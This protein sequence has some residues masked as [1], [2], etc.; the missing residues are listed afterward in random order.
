MDKPSKIKSLKDAVRLWCL[1]KGYNEI[2]GADL[3]FQGENKTVG[4][5]LKE[6]KTDQEL[7]SEIMN[8]KSICNEI[9]VVITDQAERAKAVS[10]IPK[11]CGLLCYAN[12]FGLGYMY[13]VFKEATPL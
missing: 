13:E 9:Y 2:D 8:A 11:E 6:E 10:I 7:L 3:V 12:P 5:I 1:D 4:F